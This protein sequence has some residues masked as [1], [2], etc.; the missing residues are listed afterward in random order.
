MTTAYNKNIMGGVLYYNDFDIDKKYYQILFK[1]GFPIQA[2]ELSQLQSVLQNQIE[3]IGDHIFDEGSVVAGGGVSVS[4]AGFVRISTDTA[5]DPTTLQ[6]MI[7]QTVRG[8]SAGVTTD[9]KVVS[10]LSG[11]TLE[12][13]N[14][15]MLFV[16]YLTPGTFN[17]NQSLT[18][19]GTSNIGVTLTSLSGQSAPGVGTVS[20]FV[21]VNDGIY[22][23][24]GYFAKVNRQS[25]PSY[26]DDSTLNYRVFSNTFNS[27][28]LVKTNE[29]VTSDE[30]TSLRDPSFGFSNFNS[31]GADRF[32]VDLTL[33]QRGLTGSSVLGY[34]LQDKT[35][36]IELV[37]IVDGT[38][39]RRVKYPDYAE[40]EK[41]LARRTYDES[42]HYTVDPFPI[43]IDSYQDTFGVVD[44]SKFGIRIC[45]GKA[46]VKGYEFETIAE[47]K[48]EDDYPTETFEVVTRPLES[49]M[50]VN[51]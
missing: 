3:K 30:D 48:L 13:D 29:V 36:F 47:N 42:G 8:T 23:T 26:T 49:L 45:P 31:P 16:Q 20:N 19:V 32:K 41:T 25:V 34:Q 11:S 4:T 50:V 12:N 17:E 44:R 18:T 51:I 24:G 46:Y 15:Q 7:G 43:E 28:G 27:I 9:A 1:P 2:R 33:G 37:K 39:T 10:V 21:T 40:L 38:V 22:Y 35:D 14:Y 5:L 6:N